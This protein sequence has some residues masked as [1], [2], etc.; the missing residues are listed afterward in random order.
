MT[1]SVD[2]TRPP[3]L[4]LPHGGGPLPLLGDAGHK[5]LVAFMQGLGAGLG[6]PAAILVISAHWEEAQATISSASRPGMIYD[7]YGFPQESYSISY[8]APGDPQLAQAIYELLHSSGI[9]VRLDAQRGFDHGLY[10][11]LKLIYPQA[12]IP[13]LQLSLLGNL[14][15]VDH[16]E[17]GRA[18]AELRNRNIL[19]IG[20]GMSFHNLPAFF[21]PQRDV[22]SQPE[23]FDDWLIDTCTNPSLSDE[24]R[25]W[26][27]ANWEAAPAARF[28][29]PREEHLLPL[30][31]CYG[32]ACKQSRT[33]KVIFNQQVMG[34]R[35]TALRWD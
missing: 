8:P 18:L 6:R 17:L 31:V 21:S 16:I 14:S 25:Q 20:S 28:C 13:C 4:Y 34:K 19:I 26:Q 7:Y 3:V 12:Q 22:G 10:V 27:L 1:E 5:A 24:Q 9:K 29:H 30:H 35:V 15:P 23:A 2:Q 33:A 32:V 11:P